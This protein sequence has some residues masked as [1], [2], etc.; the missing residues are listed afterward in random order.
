M[1]RV[2]GVFLLLALAAA[3]LAFAPGAQA[4]DLTISRS[5]TRAV[6]HRVKV[7]RDY[8]GTPIVIRARL[9][10]TA[11]AYAVPREQP[12]YYLNGQPVSAR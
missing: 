5:A 10:G 8:D 12:R 1:R 4:A 3:P 2:G 6:H 7:V 9:D 11:D